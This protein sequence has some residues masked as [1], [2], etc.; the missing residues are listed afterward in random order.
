M[1]EY[2]KKTPKEVLKELGSSKRGLSEAEA[3]QRLK[4]YGL[5]EIK[6]EER[7]SPLKIFISQFRSFMVGILIIAILISL[8][9]GHILDASVIAAILIINA[10]LGFVQEYKAEKAIEALKKLVT[11]EARV[12]RNGT[13]KLIDAKY[14]VPGDI[15][16]LEEGMKVPADARLI[17]EHELETQ[18]AA[19]TGE[20]VP[21]KKTVMTYHETLPIAD[22]HNMVFSGTVITRGRGKAIV[23]ATGMQTE[24]GKIAR[25]IQTK[26]A[27]LTPLQI[28]LKK[29]GE[30]LGIG[31]LTICGIVFLM[32][33]LAGINKFTMF[34]TAI[35]LAVAAIP[36]GLPAVVTISLALGVQRMVKK[37]A[38]IRK[39]PSVETLGS[40]T[41][42][43]TDKTGTLTHNEMTVRKIWMNGKEYSV[44][45]RGYKPIGKFYLSGKVIKPKEIELI[46]KIGALCNNAR[47]QDEKIIGDPTEGALIVSA[48]KAGLIKEELELK[49]PRIAEIEFS[50]ERKRMS[51]V[52]KIGKKKILY[53]KGAP[54][55]L[56]E[57]CN[58]IY[59]NGR[60]ERLTRQ[61]KRKILA[62]NERFAKQA[63]RVLGFAY[64]DKPKE[65]D[66]VF[67]GLQ[68]MIDPPREEAKIAVQRCKEAGIKV[69][70]LTGDYKIT[71][72]AIAKE[73]GIKGKAVDG[74]ELDQIE[75]LA[76]IVEKIAV[77]ARIDPRHKVKILE[78][79]KKRGHIVAMTG[80]GV[81]DAPALKKADIG[82]AM[83]IT[84]TDVAKEASDMILLD[85]NFASIVKAVEEGRIIYENI[86][87]F[88]I[89]LLSSNLGEICTLFFALLFGMPLPVVAL[90]ILWINLVTDGLPALAL[91]VDPGDPK[92][93][94]KPPRDPKENI[95]VGRHIL[96]MIIIGLTMMAGTLFAFK[97]YADNSIDYARTMAFN[98]LVMFQM[99]NV[100]NC[101]SDRESVF[102]IGIFRNRYLVLAIAFSIFMQFVLIYTPLAGFF[103]AIAISPKDWI[104]VFL[105]S[106]SALLVGEIMKGFMR[107]WK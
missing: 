16:I 52:H 25:M 17:E 91:S 68:A 23:T 33:I 64:N 10:V 104:Y 79:L 51:T 100:L 81:N 86:R 75:N 103:K 58:R 12:V 31:A 22:Q 5:N 59:I 2:Y 49:Y 89:Y 28:K 84:G 9:I 54:E 53:C 62:V 61:L 19:L 30:F 55:I 85:D 18:E 70:M 80:D 95:I 40:V 39:L 82:V 56:L 48:A 107:K 88:V 72:E 15:I 60:V 69:I 43:C 4:R 98:V 87:K 14:L 41:V 71:A 73:L 102:K 45:G 37:N 77:Y 36:E 97:L 26:E 44:S 90:Q 42:I 46:L 67:V 32:G 83:G 99:F 7:I 38:L 20:S 6:E 35:S 65:K 13:E 93:M 92:I 63:L 105:I 96:F 24:I 50:S 29:L 8:A 21:V 106:S 3:K 27:K 78:A 94:K 57:L 1:V 34:M 47:L 101:R 11:I 74:R 76:D 66:M